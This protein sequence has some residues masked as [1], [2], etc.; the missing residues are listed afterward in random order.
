MPIVKP[1]G[2]PAPR[3]HEARLLGN[4][5]PGSG[6]RYEYERAMGATIYPAAGFTYT[7][8]EPPGGKKDVADTDIR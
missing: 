6:G 1:F 8:A 4:D 3:F 2:V 7:R 5:G